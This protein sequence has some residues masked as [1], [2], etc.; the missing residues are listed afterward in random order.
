MEN[1]LDSYISNFSLLPQV[2]KHLAYGKSRFSE[3]DFA[4]ELL[5]DSVRG[6]T[7]GGM[8][9]KRVIDYLNEIIT[10][11]PP[12]NFDKRVRDIVLK[13]KAVENNLFANW[14]SDDIYVI[15]TYTTTLNFELFINKDNHKTIYDEY[16]TN[17]LWLFGEFFIE[18]KKL[19]IEWNIDIG[20]IIKEIGFILID[21]PKFIGE[22]DTSDLTNPLIFDIETL[23]HLHRDFNDYL[24]Q[25]IDFDDFK[26]CFRNSPKKIEIKKG[27]TKSAFCYFMGRIEHKQ[28]GVS[29]L[30][31]WMHFHI[32][33]S[34]YN[35]LKTEF[36]D[37][38]KNASNDRY[39][40]S[41]TAPQRKALEMKKEIDNRLKRIPII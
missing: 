16:A 30:H 14:D 24:W 35:K 41:L 18:F 8:Q 19:C 29:S 36:T 40:F 39:D 17:C 20:K 2:M 34:N 4:N 33:G 9:T 26:N 1:Q 15:N 32:G 23:R 25:S 31:E 11:T 28:T 21:S 13:F 27:I 3:N 12:Q 10:N 37:M 22:L 7:K 5:K 38:A 6:T